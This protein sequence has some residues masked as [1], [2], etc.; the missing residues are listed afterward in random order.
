MLQPSQGLLMQY[1]ITIL[2]GNY[3]TCLSPQPTHLLTTSSTALTP[4]SLASTA[5]HSLCSFPQASQ[6]CFACFSASSRW[7]NRSTLLTQGTLRTIPLSL[8]LVGGRWE[9]SGYKP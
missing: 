7:I 5:N 9:R 8:R 6:T 2:D 1:P 4:F 3:N